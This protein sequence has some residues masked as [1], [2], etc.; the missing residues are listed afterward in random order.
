MNE[1]LSRAVV[2][3]VVALVLVSVPAVGVTAGQDGAAGDGPGATLSSAF[4]AQG[5]SV[6][7]GA[8]P[9]D[10]TF[11]SGF[12]SRVSSVVA[13]YNEEQPELGTGGGLV[14]GSVVNFHVTAPDG[15]EAVVSFRLTDENQITDQR[16]GPRDDAKIRMTTDTATFDGIAAADAPGQAFAGALE[17]GDV[18][19]TGRG[20]GSSI[21]W[22]VVNKLR[23]LTVLV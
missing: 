4:D 17:S 12:Y 3:V 22:F 8:Q 11:D 13:A 21:V 1:Q 7:T 9:P 14:T 20:L 10:A 6:G 15:D 16:A 18:R 5:E 2:A 19:I 23:G